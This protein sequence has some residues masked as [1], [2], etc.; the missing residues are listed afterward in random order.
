MKLF[1]ALVLTLIYFLTNYS[2]VSAQYG[3]YGQPSP[4][5]TILVDKMV[6]KPS[7][8]KGG[9]TNEATGAIYVDN[10]SASDSRYKAGQTVFFKIRVKNTSNIKLTNVTLKDFI[11]SYLETI[12]GPGTYDANSRTIT[13]NAGDFEANQEKIYY[14]KTQVAGQNNLPSDK[15]LFC[16]VNKAQVSNG[17]VSDEDTSQLC[18]EKEVVGAP[19][20]PSAGPEMGLVLLMINAL[21]IGVGLLIK[22]KAS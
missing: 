21:G 13:F 16:I 8:T 1:V 4:A 14:L 12:E 19:Q 17:S 5:M 6:A 22:N 7:I 15:G 20:V 11:P 2:I 18:I 10:L 3:Q 9:A